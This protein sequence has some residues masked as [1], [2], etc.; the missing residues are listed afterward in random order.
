[1]P[2]AAI[3]IGDSTWGG[4]VIEFNRTHDTV[5]ETSDHGPFNAWGRD[6]AWCLAQSHGPYTADRS[7]D[8][9]D[10]LV[11]A[12]EPVIVRNNFF[13]EK[14]GWGLDLDDGAS[15]YKIYNNISVGGVSL[16]WRE[17]AYREVYNNIWY[18]SKAAPC[19]HVGNNYNHDRYYNNITVMDPGDAEWPSGWPWW[20]Q[21]F[22]SVIA[23]PA[24]GPWFEEIDRNCFY[25]TKGEFQAVVDQLRSEDGKRNPR[26]YNLAEWQALGWDQNSVFADPLFVDPANHD[27]RVRP[28]PPRSNSALSISRWAHGA[29]PKSF[30][31]MAPKS[32]I[33]P[34]G[35]T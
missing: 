20:P 12:M 9:W 33:P 16:K 1:M 15:N 27:F 11:D 22:H 6:R 24:T 4:H 26:R 23:P 10:V 5:R 28:N 32:G 14:S 29:S 35:R 7:I 30:Q 3:C 18:M 19:F 13:N 21:M 2:R 31:E 17:G 8:A 34:D 25:S